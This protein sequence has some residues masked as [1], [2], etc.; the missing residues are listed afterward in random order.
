MY[1]RGLLR[2]AF[3][4]SEEALR[5]RRRERAV[6]MRE[7]DEVR[8]PRELLVAL[9]VLVLVDVLALRYGSDSRPMRTRD[10]H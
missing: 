3:G 10:G 8:V 1:L 4:E 6:L 5:R 9:G 2:T 7:R